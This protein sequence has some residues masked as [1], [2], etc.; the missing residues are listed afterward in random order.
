MSS[1][2]LPADVSVM[3]VVLPHE[4]SAVADARRR[5]AGYLKRH[6]V[7]ENACDDAQLVLSELLSNAIRYAPP[8]PDGE[9][10]AAWWIDKAGI[11]IEVTDGCGDTEPQRINDPH[12]E[13][14]GGRGLAIVE[15]L[16][17]EWTVRTADKRR[18]VHAIVPR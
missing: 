5:L 10:H 16:T 13:S 8:L 17:V 9:V 12:P 15:M 6:R 1:A 4:V 11:H 14:I 2:T 3:D 18:T 7:A